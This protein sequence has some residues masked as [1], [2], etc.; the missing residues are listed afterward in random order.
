[1][2]AACSGL[3]ARWQAAE[4]ALYA[5]PRTAV[6]A[7][8]P[9]ASAA[10]VVEVIAAGNP[11]SAAARCC[12]CLWPAAAAAAC[13]HCCFASCCCLPIGRSTGCHCC[14]TLLLLQAPQAR[15]TWAG[16]GLLR[17]GSGRPTQARR[18]QTTMCR[19][20]RYWGRK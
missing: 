12:L 20:R 1:M 19:V 8:A 9:V 2:E 13:C 6:V 16:L 14:W 18:S 3:H 4:V 7:E 17:S 5:R 10:P 15:R 11:C